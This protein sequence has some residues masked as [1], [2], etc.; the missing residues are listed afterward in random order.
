MCPKSMTCSR[1]KGFILDHFTVSAFLNIFSKYISR[2]TILV[3]MKPLIEENFQKQSKNEGY[4]QQPR[5]PHITTMDLHVFISWQFL[6]FAI[7]YHFSIS[8]LFP[9]WKL[10]SSNYCSR[11]RVKN[12]SCSAQV[13]FNKFKMRKNVPCVCPSNCT[14]S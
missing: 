11:K 12:L 5:V 8:L 4:F 10:L 9:I 13:I 3:L 1:K 6:Y 14:W 7:S 2:H